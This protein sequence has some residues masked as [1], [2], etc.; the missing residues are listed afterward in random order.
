MA[1]QAAIRVI[2]PWQQAGAATPGPGWKLQSRKGHR[3][4]QSADRRSMHSAP[5]VEAVNFHRDAVRGRV[6][7]D[8]LLSKLPW[9]KR[10]IVSNAPQTR[11]PDLSQDRILRGRHHVQ[12]HGPG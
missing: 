8:I 9:S 3:Q 7:E 12:Q 1:G 10:K 6:A 4:S 11:R 5:P 2:A